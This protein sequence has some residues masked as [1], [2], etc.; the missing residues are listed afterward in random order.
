M[1]LTELRRNYGRKT[2]YNIGQRP[3]LQLILCLRGWQMKKWDVIKPQNEAPGY[4]DGSGRQQVE[5][6]AKETI[7]EVLGLVSTS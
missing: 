3:T 4:L 2:F 5:A 6:A 7:D 1:I